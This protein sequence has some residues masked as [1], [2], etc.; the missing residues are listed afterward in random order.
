MPQVVVHM[1]KG[2]TPGQKKSILDAVHGAIVD[3][4]KTP[5][6]D[7][8]QRVLE[9]E[10]EDFEVSQGRSPDFLLIEMTVFP[11][12]TLAAKRVLY[13][14]LADRLLGLGLDP[15][16]CMVIVKE[17]P[18]ENWGIR[19]GQAACDVDLGYKLNV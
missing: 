7:R 11:G 10:P 1:R 3:G 6:T 16:E 14:S 12:R 18:L 17:N 8:F 15:A 4:F 13:R 19:G 2:R 9:Y 5:D